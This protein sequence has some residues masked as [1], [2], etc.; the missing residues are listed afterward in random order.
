MGQSKKQMHAKEKG[1]HERIAEIERELRMPV[2]DK[3]K[4][5]DLEY[6]LERL[7]RRA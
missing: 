1:L 5:A 3:V 7:K 6:E 2:I 4:R